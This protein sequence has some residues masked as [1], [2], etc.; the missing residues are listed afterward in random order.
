MISL[1]VMFVI[2]RGKRGTCRQV[3]DLET[4][5]MLFPDPRHGMLRCAC[6][7][8]L[9]RTSSYVV[10]TAPDAQVRRTSNFCPTRR[11]RQLLF[12]KYVVRHKV[13][14]ASG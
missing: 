1:I 13:R 5:H 7:P 2:T 9:A 3:A 12:Q 6:G 14:T 10:L 8:A 11:T 4:K